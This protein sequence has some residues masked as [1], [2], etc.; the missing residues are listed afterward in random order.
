MPQVALWHIVIAGVFWLRLIQR[1]DEGCDVGWTGGVVS[2]SNEVGIGGGRLESGK[3]VWDDS[4][5]MTQS[6]TQHVPISTLI[7]IQA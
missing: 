3:I 7:W 4:S 2:H 5:K 1:G 6:A